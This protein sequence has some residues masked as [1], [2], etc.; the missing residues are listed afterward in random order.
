MNDNVIFTDELL[1]KDAF[2]YDESSSI[3][4][5]KAL[6]QELIFHYEN[7]SMYRSFC[8]RKGFSPYEDFGL[9]DIPPVSVSV[10]KNLGSSLSSVPEDDIRLKIQSSAT[11]GVPS[12][13]A[14]DKITS[15][16]QSKAMIRVVQNFIGKGMKPFL[17][18]DIDPRNGFSAQLGARFAAVSGYLKFSNKT[19]YFLKTRE[20]GTSFF[21]VT[22]MRE[23]LDG[24]GDR[25]VVLFGFTY[26]LYS[27]VIKEIDNSNTIIKLPVGSKIIHIGGWKK[28]EKEK[29]DKQ[30]FNKSLA[31]TFGV[32]TSD[33]IDIYGFTEQM[34]LNYPDCP[35]GWKHTSLYSRVIVRDPVTHEVL[36]DGEEGVL[37]FVSPIPHSYPGNAVLT[38]DLGL[39]AKE[40]YSESLSGIKFKITGRMKKAEVRGCGDILSQK[41]TFHDVNLYQN[42]SKGKLVPIMYLGQLLD[43]DQNS[44]LRS[45]ISS[46]KKE[47]QWIR[48]QPTEAIIGLISSVAKTWIDNPNLQSLKEKGLIFVSQWL[49]EKNLRTICESG[50]R[51][52]IGYLDHFESFMGS[53]G[54]MLRA[55]PRGLVCH[56]LAGN[57]QILGV[58]A[59]VQAIIS[60]N[61]NLLRVSSKDDGVFKSLLDTFK[62][63]IYTTSDGYTINGN[64]L[65]KTIALISY[66]HTNRELGEI[67]SSEADVRIAWGGREAVQTV[68]CFPAKIG[69]ETV[70]FGP[71]LSFAVISKES[72]ETLKE[73]KMLA[74]RL[75]V[76]VSVFDQTG[77]A[78][79]HNLYIEKGGNVSID[80]F[81]DLFNQEMKKTEIRIPKGEMSVEQ[82]SQIHSI[83]GVYDFKGK[84]LGTDSMSYTILVENENNYEICP[85]VYSR[86]IFIHP[87]DSIFECLDNVT[88]DIQTI[89][90]A[91][92]E[93]KA[94]EF[95]EMATER[96]VERLP[97]IGSM[98][99]FEMPWDG[100]FLLDRLVRWNTLGGPLV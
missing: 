60:K 62:G 89:G 30:E 97:K 37:E 14:V 72:L 59:L 64:D 40:R 4:F 35:D 25:P 28:L 86:V 18:M 11:S 15:K 51:G 67:M 48:R 32:N 73:A 47:Q 39:I 94:L 52:N 16:R 74:R 66:P 71:K 70:I 68:A 55:N 98:L 96:G 100:I 57:V 24:V 44:Q 46:L 42:G 87:V 77:C 95:A 29:I 88:E 50:L 12:T 13:V 26:I 79:P 43:E 53:S 65:L 91:G 22:S 56:W 76:D 54:H 82:I 49:S 61:V 41:L 2:Q 78:S 33:I 27:N 17:I 19:G 84:V 31:R 63:V 3:L 83:R 20:D 7:N 10:F 8:E 5:N 81:I 21:D 75:S 34:G 58:F 80:D 90:F 1:E 99:N 36:P 6:K 85:P 38:D 92:K 9:E 69:S 93:N 23:F 45:I